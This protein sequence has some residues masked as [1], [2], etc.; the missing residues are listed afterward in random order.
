MLS[1]LRQL[2]LVARR[3]QW[4][5]AIASVLL[6]FAVACDVRPCSETGCP[7]GY[8][9]EATVC[10][11]SSGV[12]ADHGH[13][14]S[15][16]PDSEERDAHHEHDVALSDGG[17]DDARADTPSGDP[18]GP[19]NTDADGHDALDAD[20]DS[21][22][23]EADDAGSDPDAQTD[24][25]LLTAMSDC[26]THQVLSDQGFFGPTCA[27]DPVLRATAPERVGPV[28][29]AFHLVESG[30]ELDVDLA[31][32]AD[33]LRSRFTPIG[34]DL[35]FVN[36]ETPNRITD[37]RYRELDVR[38]VR[39]RN[40]L[41]GMN[42]WPDAVDVYLGHLQGAGGVAAQIGVGGRVGSAD[43]S[44]TDV[45]EPVTVIAHELGHTL[46]LYH[47]FQDFSGPTMDPC[48]GDYVCDT[49]V[50]PGR[51]VGSACREAE[52][53]VTCHL[54]GV[55]LIPPFR[56]VMSY[57]NCA[58]ASGSGRFTPQQ[59]ELMRCTIQDQF[60]YAISDSPGDPCSSDEQCQIAERCVLG[61]CE[62][63][64]EC[65]SDTDCGRG[66]CR[67]CACVVDESTCT[68]ETDADCGLGWSCERCLCEPEC[69]SDWSCDTG[70]Q[71][72]AGICEPFESPSGLPAC[73]AVTPCHCAP[74]PPGAFPFARRA[75]PECAGG[76][77]E[78]IECGWCDI[79]W[80]Y[81]GPE[82]GERCLCLPE[83]GS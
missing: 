12:E 47:T 52:C 62:P 58:V 37:P 50:D 18:T 82:W 19:D 72:I 46:G 70:E 78:F 29:V 33:E 11:P 67:A 9:C 10:M 41:L 7:P 66:E 5:S 75:G 79:P 36:V 61:S 60:S 20:S 3:G 48:L 77:V 74:P 30:Y 54:G 65:T 83:R 57:W 1:D 25:S 43:G 27:T 2:P 56:N 35:H 4:F 17:V 13:D 21:E 44:I 59:G 73:A 45:D 23:V 71:C 42:N 49:P 40:E 39:L 55:T 15:G 8:R 69:S 53:S 34:V 32:V 63:D 31:A 22:T 80:V 76:T 24:S 51:G 6:A 81:F 16:S 68:C 14:G 38:N 28:R 26:A 64:C